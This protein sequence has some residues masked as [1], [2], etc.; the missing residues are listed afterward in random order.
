MTAVWSGREPR[1]RLKCT[2]ENREEEEKE[3][4]EEEEALESLFK[5]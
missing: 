1:S 4:K 3:E 5:T 2:T